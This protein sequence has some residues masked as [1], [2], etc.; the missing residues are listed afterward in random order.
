MPIGK[1]A[2]VK[3]VIVM[4]TDLCM[5]KGKMIAQGAHAS[6]KVLLDHNFGKGGCGFWDE[7]HEWLDGS[8]A[9]I[10]VRVESKE[11][12]LD[13]MKKAEELGIPSALIIDS[14]KTMFHGVP[15]ETCCAIGPACSEVIDKVTGHLRLY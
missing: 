5:T 9:K 1:G 14:G 15:T 13:I 4:R 10:C 7:L 12:L 11:E 8:F 6:M 3:Q 2:G